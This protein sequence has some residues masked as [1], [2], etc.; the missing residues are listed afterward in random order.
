ME[1][2]ALPLLG[3][4]V[5]TQAARHEQAER[6]AVTDGRACSRLRGTALFKK[7]VVLGGG[8]AVPERQIYTDLNYISRAKYPRCTR[9]STK[10]R[11]SD[12]T[13]QGRVPGSSLSSPSAS[14]PFSTA[15]RLGSTAPL[16]PLPVGPPPGQWSLQL[17][18]IHPHALRL[19]DREKQALPGWGS[20]LG[21]KGGVGEGLR[22][23]PG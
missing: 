22:G 16:S 19:A 13:G 4:G 5:G 21:L 10:Q 7:S 18:L 12:E 3:S 9:L 1:I 2:S 8:S 6:V 11:I 15:P 20:G 17:I 23:R 14:R